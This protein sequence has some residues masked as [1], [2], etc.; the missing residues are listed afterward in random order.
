MH[1]AEFSCPSCAIPLRVKD[2]GFVGRTIPCPDC[3]RHV[4]IVQSDTGR[5]E[6]HLADESPAEQRE[7]GPS[8]WSNPTTIGW[9]VA[10][11][12]A[13]GLGWF[14]LHDPSPR[15]D[16]MIAA[17]ANAPDVRDSS[18]HEKP[19]LDADD[20][21]DDDDPAARLAALHQQ[22]HA[23]TA[24]ANQFPTG[25]VAQETL[26]PSER[27]SWIASLISTRDPDIQPAWDRPWNDPP[28]S[29]FVRRQQPAWLNPR[30]ESMVSDDRY[31]AT[32][33]VGV[34]GV[35]EDAASLPAGHPRAGIFGHDRRVR[36]DEIGD[37][38]ANTMLI[39]GVEDHLGSWAAGGEATVRGFSAEPYIGGPDGFGTGEGESMQV[40]MADGSVRTVSRETDP[41]VIRRMAAIND[42]L[43][44]DPSTP[45]EPGGQSEQRPE[46]VAIDDSSAAADPAELNNA[47]RPI[48]VA[49]MI[50][51]IAGAEDT[52]IDVVL[53]E[54]P[55]EYDVDTALAQKIAEF[56][57]TDPVPLRSLLRLIEEM[58]AVPIHYDELAPESVPQ[59][60]KPVKVTLGQ[61]TVGGILQA[62]LQTAELTFDPRPAGVFV[63][64]PEDSHTAGQ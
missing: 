17:G 38:L 29:R 33:F 55:V 2:R 36:L 46:T 45:G 26:V 10:G 49:A 47:D 52:P 42:G 51:D 34:A 16:H 3:G 37:G 15:K 48:D 11:C 23:V 21:A 58:A 5:I 9:I 43:P 28:N 35:G 44:L 39:A 50:A 41:R 31:P 24:Q 20:K 14:V 57:Q 59:L 60:D 4:R 63:M 32:H 27:L 61:T 18:I 25:T 12:L 56:R 22:L 54:P 6:G 1:V 40:L 30:I 7:S 64:R 53:A 8:V 62:V 13:A 19:Q